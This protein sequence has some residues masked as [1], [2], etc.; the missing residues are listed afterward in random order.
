MNKLK[1][2]VKTCETC[3]STFRGGNRARYCKKCLTKNC[4]YCGKEFTGKMAHIKRGWCRYCSKS[5]S[6][7]ANPIDQSIVKHLYGKDHPNWNG[8]KTLRKDGYILISN[9]GNRCFEHRAIMEKLL[10]RKLE[11]HEH[12]HH[13][14]GIKTDNRVE[15]LLLIDIR[16]HTSLEHKLGTFDNWKIKQRKYKLDPLTCE[17]C[18]VSYWKRQRYNTR[19]FCSASCRNMWMSNY[20]RFHNPRFK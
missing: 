8:G 9:N 2:F 20:Y 12:V 17:Q 7:K 4:E 3:N 10:K 1:S 6:K 5:C 14:N 19:R 11:K 15:N 16:N 18:G 13:I